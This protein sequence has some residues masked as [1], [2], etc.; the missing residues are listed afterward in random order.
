M[1]PLSVSKADQYSGIPNKRSKTFTRDIPR[2]P[3]DDN[4]QNPCVHIS[5]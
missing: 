3:Q 2:I 4:P 5:A 1:E